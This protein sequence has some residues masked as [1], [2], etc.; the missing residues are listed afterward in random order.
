MNEARLTM[1][2]TTYWDRLRKDQP[3]PL[4][5]QFNSSAIEDIWKQCLLFVVIPTTGGRSPS[6]NFSA[7]GENLSALYARTVIGQVFSPNQR[8]IPG[9]NV[10]KRVDEIM[11]NP[12]PLMDEGQFIS[13]RGKIIKYRSCLLPFGKDG[14]V[15]HIVAGLSWREF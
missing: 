12:V 2:L 3:L 6:L 10:M 4:F 13:S 9:T 15:T 7:V 11:A 14:L 8:D 1:R 5:S